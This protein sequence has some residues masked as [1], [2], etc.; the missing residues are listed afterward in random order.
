MLAEGG[1]TTRRS[2]RCRPTALG[3]GP[4]PRPSLDLARDDPEPVE[5]LRGP[6]VA[7]RPAISADLKVH[8]CEG[9]VFFV[10]FVRAVLSAAST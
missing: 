4:R 6:P 10:T 1:L 2:C 9:V 8:P 7:S 5:G 3:T